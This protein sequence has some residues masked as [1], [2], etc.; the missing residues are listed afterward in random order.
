MRAISSGIAVALVAAVTAAGQSARVEGM[1]AFH[2]GRYSVALAK[3]K[4]A[5]AD[6]KD[7]HGESVSGADG[8]GVGRL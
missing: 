4:A 7:S 6:P 1:A 5:A 2:E 3:L 8:G